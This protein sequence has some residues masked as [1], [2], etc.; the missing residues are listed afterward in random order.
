ML[1][2][3]FLHLPKWVVE[4]TFHQIFWQRKKELQFL[5]KKS[6][7]KGEKWFSVLASGY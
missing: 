1:Y 5:P 7:G 4:V 2:D 3:F 6:G